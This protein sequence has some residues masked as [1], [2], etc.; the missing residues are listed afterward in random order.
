MKL[1]VLGCHGGE[2]PKCRTTC[3]L[4]D[5]VL[6]LDAG[7][8]CQALPLDELCKVD[9]I[10]IGRLPAHES[11]PAHAALEAALILMWAIGGSLSAIS[12]GTQAITARRFGGGDDRAAGAVLTNSLA[13]A[14]AT[15]TLTSIGGW[16]LAPVLFRRISH[17]PAVL[18]IGIP[19]FAGIQPNI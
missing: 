17:D 14:F 15:S 18:A 13:V 10:L 12:V 16:F 2:L 4:L 5:G 6:A 7:S 1:R 9:H 3:F 19:E 8:M 11:V